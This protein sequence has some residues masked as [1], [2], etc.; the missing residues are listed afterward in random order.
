MERFK[1]I[2]DITLRDFYGSVSNNTVTETETLLDINDNKNK[3]RRT[4]GISTTEFRNKS[5]KDLCLSLNDNQTLYQYLNNMKK[6]GNPLIADCKY[7]ASGESNPRKIELKMSLSQFGDEECM[8]FIFKDATQRDIITRLADNNKY[9]DNLLSSISHEL[10]TPLNGNINFIESAIL[11]PSISQYMKDHFLIPAQRSG[12]VLL[13]LINDIL[14]FSQINANQIRMVFTQDNLKETCKECVE[15]IR[16][17]ASKKKLDLIF[18]YDDSV[19]KM[20]ITDHNRLS[21]ILLNLL[22]NALKFTFKGQIEVSVSSVDKNVKISVTDTGMGIKDCDKDRLFRA[23]GKLDLGQEMQINSSGVGLGLSISNALSKLLGPSTNTGII[24]ES[25]FGEGSIFSFVIS[26][27]KSSIISSKVRIPSHKMQLTSLEIAEEN[28]LIRYSGR[29]HKQRFLNPPS[30]L[31]SFH[32]FKAEMKNSSESS[33]NLDASQATICTCVPVLIADDDAFN[34]MAL[35][36]MLKLFGVKSESAF[37]GQEVLNKVDTRLNQRCG[38][39]CRPYQ[40]IFMDCSMPILDGF[41]ATKKLKEDRRLD[42]TV[43]IGCT[44]FSAEETIKKCKDSGMKEVI[45]KPLDKSHLNRV[46]KMYCC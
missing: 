18:N 45:L 39:N 9:K 15:L 16:G 8:I 25:K 29:V 12:K 43:I 26:E 2:T 46:L 27:M 19:P 7:H 38:P 11:E 10:R 3:S 41:E 31:T 17:Q 1:L 4:I 6:E 37:N 34:V 33:K 24:L 35:E 14:D 20:F 21:Q 30:R 22:S 44:A 5:L 32:S 42:S 36:Y 23:F 28:A 13:H 40:V